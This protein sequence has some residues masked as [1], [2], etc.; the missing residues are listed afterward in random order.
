MRSPGGY[1]LL[2]AI[3]IANIIL[4]MS[5]GIF[6]IALKEVTLTTYIKDSQSAFSAA[7]HMLECALYW[8]M[9]Y[10][11]NG[12]PYTI[13]ATSSSPG[14]TP[15]PSNPGLLDNAVCDGVRLD[16]SGAG[17]T[18]WNVITTGPPAPSGI[19]TFGLKFPNGTCADVRILKDSLGMLVT[20]NGYNNCNVNNPRRTQRTIEVSTNL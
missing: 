20:S 6:S 19:T 7:D 17:G 18:G 12:M 11:R 1:A 8:D 3:L 5:L 13:F 4:A 9:A 2:L 16:N 15:I 14:Y 10:V